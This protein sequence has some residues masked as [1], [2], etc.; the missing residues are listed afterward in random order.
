MKISVH[1]LV[2]VNTPVP[3]TMHSIPKYVSFLVTLDT[4]Y[5]FIVSGKMFVYATRSSITEES[6]LRPKNF[7]NFMMQI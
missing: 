4:E 5:L 1:I 7:C 3:V 6:L 2:P